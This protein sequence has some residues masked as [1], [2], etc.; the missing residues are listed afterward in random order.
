MLLAEKSRRK[1]NHKR[2]EKPEF[3]E[4]QSFSADITFLSEIIKRSFAESICSAVP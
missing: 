2:S 4:I 3:K 1:V